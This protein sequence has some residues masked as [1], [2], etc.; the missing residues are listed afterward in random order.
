MAMAGADYIIDE[1]DCSIPSMP[2]RLNL[3]CGEHRL[4]GY[5][6][7]DRKDGHEIY[8]LDVPNES[9]SI[10]RASHVLEHFGHREVK[11][12]IDHWVSK[13][14][15]GGCLRLAVPDFEWIAKQ[16]LAGQP[17]P[18]QSYV[19]G[20]HTDSDDKHGCV[21]DRECLAELMCSAGL[22]RI[23]EWKSELDDCATYECSLNLQGFKPLGR[24]VDMS[25]VLAFLSA[26]R[27]GPIMHFRFA[28]H[29]FGRLSIRY[30]IGQGAYWHQ[31]LS[32][33]LEGGIETGA[34]FLLTCDYDTIFTA[35]DVN[36]LIRIMRAFPDVDAL[37]PVQSKRYGDR[38][39]F[40]MLDNNGKLRETANA[41]EFQRHAVPISTGHFGLTVFRA[42]SLDKLPRPWMTGTANHDGR[43]SEGKVDADMEFWKRWR[44][45]GLKLCLA[46]RVAVGHLQEVIAWPGR[47][48]APVYQSIGDY[49]EHGIPA[50]V[51]RV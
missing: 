8:P 23:G 37:C 4:E 6:N 36:E 12:V 34:E 35:S 51:E 41:S 11:G 2:L 48:M 44:E 18:V 32:E 21:F 14:Q 9:C 39:L 50:E 43:W 22:E 3:G 19:M 42:S 29:A 26:P 38:P 5:E 31:I 17:I 7:L 46:P 27:F 33:M 49:D 40:T 15:P 16:Y 10:I 28:S 24:S 47:D 20:G 13:L 1:G 45:H 25:G 30:Q